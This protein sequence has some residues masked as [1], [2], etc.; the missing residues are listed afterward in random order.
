[1]QRAYRVGVDIGGTFTDIV[2]SADDGALARRKVLS[3]PGDYAEAVIAGTM[4]ALGDLALAPG[5]PSEVIHATTI[6]TNAILEHK[7]G[8]CAVVTTSG[9]RDVLEIGR[10][11]M[12]ELYNLF[13]EKR[14]LLVPRR[15]VFEIPE[16]IDAAG[17]V[18]EPLT[19]AA[20]RRVVAA[21]KAAGIPSVAVC[22]INSHANPAHERAIAAA[23]LSALPALEVSISSEILP[24]PGEYERTSTTMINAYVKPLV[25]AYLDRLATRL[26]D[27]GVSGP[28]YI[29]QCGGGLTSVRTA[30]QQPATMVESGP[31]AGVLA[32]RDLAQ[33]LGLDRVIAFDMGGTTA[34]ASLVENGVV[35]RT[36]EYEVGGRISAT[37]RLTGGGGYPINLP[38]IDVAEVGAGGGSIA[39]LDGGSGLHVGPHSAGAVPGPACYG[40][41]GVAPTVTDANVVIGYLNPEAIAGGSI[42]IDRHAAAR[43]IDQLTGTLRLDRLRTAHGV[44]LIAN[45]EMVGAI[46]AVSTQRGRDPRD[47]ALVAFGG[48]GPLHAVELARAVGLRLVV[49]PEHPG[50]FSALGLLRTDLEFQS[51]RMLYRDLDDAAV[52]PLNTAL[53]ALRREVDAIAKS[54]IGGTRMLSYE[55]ELEL[56]Y[57]GQ[58]FELPLTMPYR[59]LAR[60]DVAPLRERFEAEHERTYGHR[61]GAE[62]VIVV[63]ARLRARK[64]PGAM[65]AAAGP[66]QATSSTRPRRT[67]PAY[68]GPELGSVE[69]PVIARD[70]LGATAR[71]GPLLVEEYDT[72]VVVPPGCTASRHKLGPI[73]IEVDTVPVASS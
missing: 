3:T 72:V 30:S 45:A 69:T 64:P 7:G 52:A 2:V 35:H 31:A 44:H 27:H 53:T 73:M 32:A 17:L 15:H 54:E 23:L 50:L 12:P 42:A 46:R 49:V 29:M 47:F 16:R 22:L 10:L 70:E 34:K 63:A 24:R 67:R 56:R 38:V 71:P 55:I 60:A 26:R 8:P 68:F 51:T 36:A 6:A 4:A 41:G 58:T 66:A 19:K 39:W 11:R 61:G 14:R 48:S 13:Y 18:V 43:A 37:A 21:V 59:R 5:G 57:W 28:L 25:R 40:Q 9:F 20:L 62:R 65:I 1:M 33:R